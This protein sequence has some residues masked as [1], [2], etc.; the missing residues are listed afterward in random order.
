MK[1]AIVEG[2]TPHDAPAGRKSAVLLS[3]VGSSTDKSLCLF[4][5]Q[6]T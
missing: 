5:Y 3:R 1:R 4:S 6:G 2:Q